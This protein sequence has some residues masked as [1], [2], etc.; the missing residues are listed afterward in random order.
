MGPVARVPSTMN[1]EQDAGSRVR[2]AAGQT[3]R[4]Q[5]MSQPGAL[6]ISRREG[7]LRYSHCTRDGLVANQVVP[8]F[9]QIMKPAGRDSEAQSE[10]HSVK[11]SKPAHHQAD[12]ITPARSP[13]T[14]SCFQMQP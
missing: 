7:E 9:P 12:R 10:T 4:M 6:E 11:Q 5:T 14:F 3:P 1:E 13:P 8:E 2:A